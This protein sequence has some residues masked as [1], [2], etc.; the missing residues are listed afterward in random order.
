MS[1]RFTLRT[2]PIAGVV[3]VTRQRLG[4]A[5]GYLE[6]LFCAAELA[7]IGWTGPIA[8]I[9]RTRSESRGTLR[10]LH[11]QH[12]PHAEAKLIFCTAGAVFDVAVDLRA[13]SPTFCKWHAET[14]TVDNGEALLIPPGCAHGFQ[15]LTDGVE[16]LYLHSVAYAA[17]AEDGVRFDDPTLGIDWPLAGPTLS[18][19]DALHPPLNAAFKGLHV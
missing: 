2:T 12:P 9:N 11:Y 16:M 8:Q 6:R 14:L 5:R 17:D 4:D 1:A 15:T 13:G 10:G 19:R 7:A 3:V 18:A